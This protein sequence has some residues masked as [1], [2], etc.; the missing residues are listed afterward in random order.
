M[1]EGFLAVEITTPQKKWE[2][3]DVRSCSAPGVEG[4]FQVLMNHAPM[5][6][7]LEIGEVRL[8]SESGNKLFATSGGFLEVLN[9]KVSLLL[10]SCEEAEQ[11]N[12]ERAERSAERARERLQE[13][14]EKLDTARAEASLARALNRIRIAGKVK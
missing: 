9:N 3:K 7:Q 5:L 13:R 8:E 4:G 6:N 14:S 12:V 1:N 11:I 2:Y 10:E